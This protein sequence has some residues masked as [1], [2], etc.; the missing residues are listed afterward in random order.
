MMYASDR[1]ALA[2]SPADERDMDRAD[3][4]EREAEPRA[5]ALQDE[6]YE[7]IKERFG[8]DAACALIPDPWVDPDPA[9]TIAEARKHFTHWRDAEAERMATDYLRGEG[10]CEAVEYLEDR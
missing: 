6:A 2:P 3:A 7:W 1:I 5:D 4:I 10:R 8:E 9:A